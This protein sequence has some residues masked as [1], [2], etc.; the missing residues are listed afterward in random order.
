MKTVILGNCFEGFHWPDMARKYHACFISMNQSP[1]NIK[2]GNIGT[3]S[4]AKKKDWDWIHYERCKQRANKM[5]S[6][7]LHH[8]GSNGMKIHD[9][10]ILA[11]E[12][13]E[14]NPTS[15]KQTN[16]QTHKC[17]T[18]DVQHWELGQRVKDLLWQA[19]SPHISSLQT[20][21]YQ[22]KHYVHDTH[23]S[24]QA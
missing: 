13:W 3:V 5:S 22:H 2:R 20:I 21:I 18:L 11:R 19:N 7:R 8:R 6:S 9:Y 15:S 1:T 17:R 10:S 23:N 24:F 14:S 12:K 4:K 16:I